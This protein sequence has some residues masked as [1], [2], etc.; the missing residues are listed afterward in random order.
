MES[1]SYL[2]ICLTNAM[3]WPSSD[4]AGEP[5]GRLFNGIQFLLSTC[6]RG[7]LVRLKDTIARLRIMIFCPSGD[8]FGSASY[9]GSLDDS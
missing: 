5:S 8:H 1:D 2:A 4:Q 9:S 6:H 3:L 7:S